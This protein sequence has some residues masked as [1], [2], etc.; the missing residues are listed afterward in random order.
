MAN[1]FVESPLL[2]LFSG[3]LYLLCSVFIFIRARRNGFLYLLAYSEW[4][5]IVGI[6]FGSIFLALGVN[7]DNKIYDGYILQNGLI[8][9]YAFYHII[10][11]SIG[12]FFGAFFDKLIGVKIFDESSIESKINFSGNQVFLYRWFIFLG[13]SFLFIYMYLVGPIT[14]LITAA[15]ARGGST[16]GLEDA[17]GYLFLKNIAQ[18]GIL[19]I[20]FFPFLIDQKKFKFDI[21]LICFYGIFLYIMTGA[22]AAIL[23]TVILSVLIWFSRKSLGISEMALWFFALVS[24]GLLFTLYGK[25]LSD[26]LFSADFNGGDVVNGEFENPFGKIIGQ[27]IHLI[28]SI[29]AGAKYFLENGP[30]I[31]KAV[32]LAPFGI[33]PGWLYSYLDLQALSWQHVDLGDNIVC[34][35]TFSYPD[36]EP[37]TM[38]PYYSGVSAYLGPI[39]FGFVFGFVK[40]FVYQNIANLWYGLR[41]QSAKLWFPLLC[42]VLFSH[43]SLLIP[44][45]IGLFSFF[46]LIGC[47][48]Y[49]FRD[50][51]GK[52]TVSNPA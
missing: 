1:S 47:S 13:L 43:L 32:L 46:A 4:S 24:F 23:D 14:A 51:L 48:C 26:S 28:Y 7:S 42:F 8:G 2:A 25:G 3:L 49:V 30:T 18:I 16:E 20:V 22:R 12:M 38:P 39:V 44:N 27:F 34:L 29:D 19:S 52:F 37:C 35:N 36:A 15:A 17:S 40:F 11:F 5:Y 45:V 10:F 9:D 6:G 21:F 50:F 41:L 33:F 31:S